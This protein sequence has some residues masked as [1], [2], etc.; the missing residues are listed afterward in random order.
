M[1]NIGLWAQKNLLDWALLGAT[2]TRPSSVWVGLSLGAPASNAFSEVA[3]GSGYARQSGQ[4]AAAATPA[5]SGSASNSSAATFGPFSSSAVVSGIFVSDTSALASGNNIFFGN[6]AT[7]R[8]PL[9]GD[10]LILAA[11]SLGITL[12]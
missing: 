11:G 9:A 8:T 7:T 1:S 2:P 10:S 3:S 6:L 4:F 12:N 5:S